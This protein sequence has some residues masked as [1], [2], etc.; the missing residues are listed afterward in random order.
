MGSRKSLFRCLAIF[1][2]LFAVQQPLLTAQQAVQKSSKESHCSKKCCCKKFHALSKKVRKLER[3]V[4]S[5]TTSLS[6]VSTSVSEVSTSVS[7]VST[8]VSLLS[9]SLE[10]PS[11]KGIN[12]DDTTAVLTP[13]SHNPTQ[14]SD[15]FPFN[16]PGTSTP[17]SSIRTIHYADQV[18]A[19]EWVKYAVENSIQVLVGLTLTGDGSVEEIAAFSADYMG[20]SST[21]KSQY[22]TYVIGIAVG[23][24]ESDAA[25]IINGINNVKA[26][27]ALNQLPAA[28]VLSVLNN[29]QVSG[30][31]LW[32]NNTYPPSSATFTPA[33]LSIFAVSDVVCFNFYPYWTL[34]HIDPSI[35]PVEALAL[36]LSF[37]S[38]A[39]EFSL[40]LNECGGVR[41][42][43][44]AAGITKP[45]W[46]GET[47][48]SSTTVNASEVPGWSSV[49]NLQSYYT[50]FLGWNTL[51]KFLPQSS[52]TLES[53]P[54]RTFYFCVRDVSNAGSFGLNTSSSILT[55]KF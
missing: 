45:F 27:Q 48:W 30:S 52:P 46:C 15:T 31:N 54:E 17:I 22:D 19:K 2:M 44:A 38:T 14:S 12:I 24:E 53:P 9:I 13:S 39:S 21:L 8:S 11:Q 49:A 1:T 55:P 41:Y 36:C 43:M 47:G 50:R 18:P 4:E 51:N 26:K 37:T 33:A 32:I 25:T 34:G 10:T 16:W 6:S 40:L 7:A 29:V 23:N 3:L 20:A 5:L 28:P 35:N 42:A